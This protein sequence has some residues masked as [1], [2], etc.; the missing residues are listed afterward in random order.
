MGD[1]T[2]HIFENLLA[3]KRIWVEEQHV[4]PAVNQDRRCFWDCEKRVYRALEVNRRTPLERY[5]TIDIHLVVELYEFV[6]LR[7][8]VRCPVR[9]KRQT[10]NRV[11]DSQRL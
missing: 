6:L 11:S 8:T 2:S 1:Q 10:V 5:P 9:S 7:V 3:F 4:R